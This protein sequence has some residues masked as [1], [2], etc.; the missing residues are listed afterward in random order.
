MQEKVWT[1]DSKRK[2]VDE[3]RRDKVFEISM[4]ITESIT[5]PVI[6]ID[7]S[8]SVDAPYQNLSRHSFNRQELLHYYLTVISNYLLDFSNGHLFGNT[9]LLH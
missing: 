9:M 1:Y 6:H 2:R 4:G 7:Q 8:Y 5:L 3:Q